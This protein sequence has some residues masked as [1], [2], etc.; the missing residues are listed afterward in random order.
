MDEFLKYEKAGRVVTLTMNNPDK[1]NSLTG[2][3]Q[4][5]EFE[6]AC[7][8]I[9]GDIDVRCVILTGAGRAFSAGGDVYAMRDRTGNSAGRPAE[10]RMNYIKGIQRIPRAFYNIHVP[11]IAAVNGPAIGAGCDLAT[12]CDIRIASEHAKFAESFVKLGIIPGDGGAWF[13]PRVIGMAKAYEMT[14][15]GDQIDA[16]EAYRIGLVSR[17]V[18]AVQLMATAGELAERIASNPSHA[19]RLTKRLMRESMHTSLETLLE[20]SAAFQALAHNEPEHDEAVAAL[21]AT[22]EAKKKG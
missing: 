12:M 19:L 14:F 20:M 5:P 22:L 11:T 13:L 15:T 6:E 7:A 21:V 2:K 3:Y 16:E 1:R 9:N 17:V 18:P 10:I 4:S 8:R